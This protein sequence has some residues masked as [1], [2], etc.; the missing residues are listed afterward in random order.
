MAEYNP[1]EY[2]SLLHHNDNYF[3][4]LQPP[5][6][7]PP[8]NY[9]SAFKY[10]VI[11]KSQNENQYKTEKPLLIEMLDQLSHLNQ[12]ESMVNQLDRLNDLESLLN[13]ISLEQTIP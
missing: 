10:P 1:P 11:S 2:K 3:C 6:Y 8:P 13:N 5:E 9:A 12:L 4:D 7:S